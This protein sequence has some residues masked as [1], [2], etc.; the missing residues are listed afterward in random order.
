MPQPIYLDHNAT[1][2][3]APEVLEA[4]Q[5]YWLSPG[6]AE[7]RHAYGRAARRGWE[8]AKDSVA[9]ILGAEPG[10]VIFTSGGTE[11]N[12]LAIFGL[13]GAEGD[14]GHVVSSPIE[15]PAIAEPIARLEVAGF[16][17]DRPAVN[18]EGLADAEKMAAT[19]RAETRLATLMLANNETGAIEPVARLASLAEARGIPVHTDAVQAVGR[20]PVDF[21]GL[22]VATLA[23]SAHKFHGPVGVGLLLVRQGIKL[24]SRLFGGGQQQGR[25]PGTVAVPLAV[26]LARALECWQAESD[27]RQAR[28]RDLRDRLES[29]LIAALG[30]DRVIRN[31]PHDDSQRLPQTLNLGLT[32]LDG[33]ALLMQLDLAG[34]AA[35]LGSACASGST[36][37][38]PTLVAMRVPDDRLRS[39]VRFSL[40]AATTEA[41]IEA[42]LPRII[43][44]VRRI[45]RAGEA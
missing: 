30:P 45:A 27:A 39:S 8:E 37:P 25:R 42:A 35:S 4:M 7:S 34:I 16:A 29:G 43:E 22:G 17:V 23:A 2:A 1:T 5:P 11:A 32:G 26:G 9:R 18:A 19:F 33:D 15:H 21:H 14:P 6:N 13:A 12:N 36:R 31:G 38:S 3:I 28:W 44:V 10:E 40:G 41:E 20:I 24:G